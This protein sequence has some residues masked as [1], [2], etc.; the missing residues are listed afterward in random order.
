MKKSK[1]TNSVLLE[2]VDELLR[3]SR[4]DDARVW[5]DLAGRISKASQLRAEVNIGEIARHT[6]NKDVIAV[7]G[8]VLG[9]GEI[10]HKVT[11][12][13]LNFSAQGKEKIK[14]AGGKCLSLRELMKA[15]P[16]GRNVRIMG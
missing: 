7:P 14:T 4:E 6:K 11:A 9:A 12:A 1:S 8:K 10:N 16:K 3:K 5:R 13:A 15:H 2:L